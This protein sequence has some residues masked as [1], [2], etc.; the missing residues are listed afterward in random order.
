[1]WASNRRNRNHE[2]EQQVNTVH[3]M[4]TTT[5]KGLNR[6]GQS[7]VEIDRQTVHNQDED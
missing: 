1:M 3:P 6:L 5:A 4:R 7:Q 2:T